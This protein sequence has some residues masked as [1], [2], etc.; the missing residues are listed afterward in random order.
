MYLCTKFCSD[1]KS[2]DN[3][4][5]IFKLTR[6]TDMALCRDRNVQN[7]PK[8]MEMERSYVETENKINS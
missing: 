7:R 3:A 8:K 2:R 6:N 5:I 4:R 1:G